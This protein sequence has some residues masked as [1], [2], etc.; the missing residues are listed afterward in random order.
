FG[1]LYVGI[2]QTD[3]S[4]KNLILKETT[5]SSSAPTID[6]NPY[7]VSV[8]Y[9]GETQVRTVILDSTKTEIFSFGNATNDTI[10]PGPIMLETPTS[11]TSSSLRLSWTN[12]GD[13]GNFGYARQYDL[14][15]SVSP[16]TAVNFGFAMPVAGEPLPGSPGTREGMTVSGLV[17]SR[18][19]YFAI[20]AADDVQ[21]WGPISN[22]VSGTTLSGTTASPKPTKILVEPLGMA[23]GSQGSKS[24]FQFDTNT[25]IIIIGVLVVAAYLLF[26]NQNKPKA[27]G[28]RR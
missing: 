6:Y 4:V 24:G 17:S 7:T 25:W 21:N 8:V 28:K 27:K 1:Q 22:V 14:R 23:Y 13:D 26:M 20:K 10:S 19:Y 18:T 9:S 2:T 16:I 11:P 5:K 12:V 15:F 3:G